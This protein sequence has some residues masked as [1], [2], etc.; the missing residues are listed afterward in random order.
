MLTIT[1]DRKL[2]AERRDPGEHWGQNSIFLQAY[3][4]MGDDE[5]EKLRQAWVGKLG[6]RDGG[7]K[8]VERS[9]EE[10]EGD[11]GS[12]SWRGEEGVG[13]GWS[14]REEEGA[15]AGEKVEGRG[16]SWSWIGWS[17][18]YGAGQGEGATGGNPE[19]H[20]AAKKS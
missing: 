8:R 6:K 13:G 19:L 4:H 16:G 12:W 1:L 7:R 15:G 3:G 11:G 10:M 2:A 17:Q 20:G 18:Y 5:D 9:M 14:W